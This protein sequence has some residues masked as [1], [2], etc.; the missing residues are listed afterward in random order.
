MFMRR[1]LDSAIELGAEDYT[2]RSSGFMGVN[3]I[4]MHNAGGLAMHG[5][6]GNLKKGYPIT[7][8][9]IISRH[10]WIDQL[11]DFFGRP[12]SY[13]VSQVQDGQAVAIIMWQGGEDAL[14]P[15]RITY[16]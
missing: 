1:K 2:L 6:S 16:V 8:A 3:H 13:L 5:E 4:L 10:P 15:D 12:R 9:R 7:I 11:Q 14:P